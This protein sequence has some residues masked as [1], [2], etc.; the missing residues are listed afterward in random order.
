MKAGHY[1]WRFADPEIVCWHFYIYSLWSRLCV[2]ACVRVCVCV[3]I[4]Q[5]PALIVPL[6]FFF[7]FGGVFVVVVVVAVVV[8]VVV[9]IDDLIMSAFKCTKK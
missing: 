9:K 3:Q 4:P 7:S 2:R 5:V 1:E 8:V 6:R